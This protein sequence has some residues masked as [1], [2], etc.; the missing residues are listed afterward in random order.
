MVPVAGHTYPEPDQ[1]FSFQFVHCYNKPYSGAREK[2]WLNSQQLLYTQW[3]PVKGFIIANCSPADLWLIFHVITSAF[4]L[5]TYQS[6][7]QWFSLPL[8]LSIC[9]VVHFQSQHL[10]LLTYTAEQIVNRFH[11]NLF[12]CLSIISLRTVSYCICIYLFVKQICS[13]GLFSLQVVYWKSWK[14]CWQRNRPLLVAE[15]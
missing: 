2:T 6:M 5:I 10:I 8:L 7:W 1:A 13:Q 3:Q 14:T 15:S 12:A 9:T 11:S 4:G